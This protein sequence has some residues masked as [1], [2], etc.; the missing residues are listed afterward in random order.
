MQV[1]I[2]AGGLGTRIA[3]ETHL[4]PKPMIEI[5]GKPILWHI[6]KIYSKWGFNDFIICLGYRGYQI[7]EYFINYRHHNSNLKIDIQGNK[8]DILDSN[9]EPWN[10]SLIET[11]DQT[12]TAGRLK[13]V[14]PYIKGDSFLMT[15][16]DGVANINLGHLIQAHKAQKKLV[17]LTAVKPPGRF[18][19][20]KMGRGNT[21][22][23]FLEKPDGDGGFINGGFFVINTKIGDWIGKDTDVW[24]KGPLPALAAQGELQAF[25]HEG[26]WQAMDTLRDK[27][28][29]EELWATGGAP[30]KV[31]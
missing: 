1:V 14:L 19:A 5:G 21:I 20:L 4:R 24:E 28:Y 18:G 30:W 3:E 12:M 10:I 16:G 22:H 29:L 25:K 2:L 9:V 17:T 26:F 31:W 15:Y 27:H 11:G 6:M 7:K 23:E 8:I 13:R